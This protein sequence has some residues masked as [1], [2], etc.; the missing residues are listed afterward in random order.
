MIPTESRASSLGASRVYGAFTRALAASRSGEH[1]ASGQGGELRLQKK[2]QKTKHIL[3]AAQ[4][5]FF[6]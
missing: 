5:G 6:S 4:V 3:V 2:K 1:G